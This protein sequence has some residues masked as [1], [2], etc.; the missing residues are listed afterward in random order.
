MTISQI[1]AASF[2]IK[3]SRIS[4]EL[5]DV[6]ISMDGDEKDV[7]EALKRIAPNTKQLIVTAKESIADRWEQMMQESKKEEL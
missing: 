3:L 1:E 4:A 5:A 2:A 6:V 7:D